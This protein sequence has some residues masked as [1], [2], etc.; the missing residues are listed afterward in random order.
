MLK[1][2]GLPLFYFGAS[3]LVS[4]PSF[5]S[6]FL[7]YYECQRILYPLS[8]AGSHAAFLRSANNTSIFHLGVLSKSLSKGADRIPSFINRLHLYFTNHPLYLGLERIEHWGYQSSKHNKTELDNKSYL[9]SA[10][11]HACLPSSSFNFF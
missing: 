10:Y 5:V 3:L 7:H 6:I 4:L 8:I 9:F 11:P 1:G 2:I